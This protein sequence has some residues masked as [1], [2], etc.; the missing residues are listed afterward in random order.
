MFLDSCPTPRNRPIIGA[1]TVGRRRL[2]KQPCRHLLIELR[3]TLTM[4]S[5]LMPVEDH[6]LMDAV[7]A[8][9]LNLA[10]YLTAT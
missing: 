9:A 4:K 5:I 6:A 10:R 1:R 3:W 2:V 8:T 7:M